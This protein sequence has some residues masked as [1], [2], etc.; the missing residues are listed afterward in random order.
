MRLTGVLLFLTFFLLPLHSHAQTEAPR[1]S[2]GCSCLHAARQDLAVAQ[3]VDGSPSPVYA[4]FTALVPQGVC[5]GL[6]TFGFS[7]R[8]PPLF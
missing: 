8:A 5:L 3:V 1:I 7:N 6:D 2:N 4:A